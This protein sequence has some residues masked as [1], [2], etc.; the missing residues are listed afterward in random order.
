[1]QTTFGP[2]PKGP[3]FLTLGKQLKQ[4]H[5]GQ[6]QRYRV[7]FEDTKGGSISFYMGMALRDKEAGNRR[8]R[9]SKRKFTLD[10]ILQ[11]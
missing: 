5:R 7:G 10:P 8:E 3:W 11:T 1:M 9:Q 2:Q 6:T 4:R